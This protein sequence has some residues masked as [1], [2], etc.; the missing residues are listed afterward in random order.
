MVALN[1][2]YASSKTLAR[3]K[4]HVGNF[5][6]EVV[7]S[8][9]E[10]RRS[11][12]NRIGEK[13]VCDC[14]L[15]SS[16]CFGPFGELIRATGAKKDAFNFRFS[17]KYEDAETGLLYY[18][19]RYYN[20]ETGRWLNRDPIQETGGLNLYMTVGNNLVNAWDFLGMYDGEG[21]GCENDFD[22]KQWKLIGEFTLTMYNVASEAGYMP[23]KHGDRMYRPK[24]LDRDFSWKFMGDVDMQ[25]TGITTDGRYVKLVST[26]SELREKVFRYRYV[27]AITGK[28]GREL[29]HNY[30]IAVDPSVIKLGEE[31]YIEGYGFRR[32]DDTGGKI[33]GKKIDLFSNVTRQE[34][35]AFGRKSNIRVY[36]RCDGE[37]SIE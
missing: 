2:A 25:G 37:E 29:E 16:H 30:S 31:V 6:G 1:T 8:V 12:R 24:G 35:L 7:E 5:F 34:A 23:L 15:T 11:S 3:S 21:C 20:A 13:Q 18:G 26:A 36:Q 14:D 33:K 9:G 28:S 27:D 17:T 19:Y 4:N 10:D 32:A 22:P